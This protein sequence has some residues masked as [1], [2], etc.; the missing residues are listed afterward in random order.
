MAI[1]ILIVTHGQF[2]KE[3]YSTV[4]DIMGKDEDVEVFGIS[5]C[6]SVE[7]IRDEITN[8]VSRLTNEGKVLIMTD[9]MGGTPTNMSLPF[10]QKKNVEIISGINMPM[11]I[12]A[13]NKK[14]KADDLCSLAQIVSEAGK[15]SVVNCRNHV[16]Y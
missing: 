4:E 13:I 9:M 11:L 15:K 6:M 5:R 12:T 14:N 2:G 1:K 8:I 7:Q 16:D 10:L 3:L